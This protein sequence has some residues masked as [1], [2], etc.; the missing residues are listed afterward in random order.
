MWG[1]RWRDWSWCCG[2]GGSWGPPA[3]R[4]MSVR[5][6]VSLCDHFHLG[7]LASSDSLLG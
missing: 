3:L 7:F 4:P 5:R 2:D 1:E 6:I